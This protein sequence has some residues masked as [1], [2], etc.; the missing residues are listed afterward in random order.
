MKGF[1]VCMRNCLMDFKLRYVAPHLRV[2]VMLKE[3]KDKL[4]PSNASESC[5][6]IDCG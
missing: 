1:F 2:C 5:L 4:N 6:K 3:T